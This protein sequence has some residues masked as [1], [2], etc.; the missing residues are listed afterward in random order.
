MNKNHDCHVEPISK[1]ATDAELAQ[2][3]YVILAVS[4]MGCPNCSARVR[5]SLL[6]LNG[7]VDAKVNHASG[8]AAVLYNPTMTRIENVIQAVAQ[9]GNDGRHRYTAQPL[10][11][12]FHEAIG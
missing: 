11:E 5:N 9:A 10:F 3:T 2:I 1:D 6:S 12:N 4:G 7:V 8:S